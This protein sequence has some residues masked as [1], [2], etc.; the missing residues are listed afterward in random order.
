MALSKGIMDGKTEY[1]ITLTLYHC[2]YCTSVTNVY[3]MN[4]TFLTVTTF[5]LQLQSIYE[6]C[7]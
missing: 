6:L 2:K 5:K 4:V 3:H 1:K 7:H